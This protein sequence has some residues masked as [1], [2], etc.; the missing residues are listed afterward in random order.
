VNAHGYA[1]ATPAR[2]PFRIEPVWHDLW[3]VRIGAGLLLLAAGT[4]AVQWRIREMRRI[5]ELE[6]QAALANERARLAKD[7]HDGLGA[8]LTQITLLSGLGDP[9]SLPAEA[10]ADRFQRLT[11]S[12]HEA[13]HSLRNIIWLTNPRADSLELLLARICESVERA[14]AAASLQCQ[15]E[16]PSEVPAVKISPDRRRDVLFAVNE[17]VNNVARHARARQV[18]LRADIADHS[19]TIVIRDDGVGFDPARGAARGGPDRGLGLASL[20]ERLLPHGGTCDIHSR[21]GEGTK[22]ILRLPLPR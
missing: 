8:N 15:V 21:L 7:L 6:R 10:L 11:A 4:V 13:L 22:V 2:L 16:F 9:R 17:A 19:V 5:A 1:S 3:P 18:T 20:A 12:T 14:A